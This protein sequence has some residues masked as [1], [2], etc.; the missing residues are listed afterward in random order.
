MFRLSVLALRFARLQSKVSN[1]SKTDH[2]PK[3]RTVLPLPTHLR[4]S[5]QP[6][7]F[8]PPRTKTLFPRASDTL[9]PAVGSTRDKG[10]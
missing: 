5:T 3:N 4:A 7:L 6:L 2:T 8:Q 1:L 9:C 10:V